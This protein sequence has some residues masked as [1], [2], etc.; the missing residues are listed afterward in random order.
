MA[1]FL[2]LL[3]FGGYRF[4]DASI[5]DESLHSMRDGIHI[6]LNENGLVEMVAHKPLPAVEGETLIK[7]AVILPHFSDFYSL[8]QERG[9]GYDEN[10]NGQ[11]QGL[12]ARYLIAGGFYGVRD[13]VF[14]R[15]GLEPVMEQHL[16]I[17]AQRGYL[18]VKGGPAQQFAQVIDP[19]GNPSQLDLPGD[20]P[21]TLWWTEMG[22]D[23][24]VLWPQHPQLVNDIIHYFHTQNRKVGCYIQDA[25]V[26]SMD[27]LYQFPFDFYEGMPGAQVNVEKFPNI[28]WIP[29]GRLNDKRY[30]AQDLTKG[31]ARAG[32]MGLYGSLDIARAEA[33]LED[34]RRGIGD[35][36]KVWKKRRATSFQPLRDW[37]ARKGALGVGS[38][39]GHLFSFTGDIR[40]ELDLL[41]ELGA[42]QPQLL[43]ALFETNPSLLGLEKPYLKPGKPANFIVFQKN[44]FWGRLVGEKVDLNFVDGKPFQSEIS[45][46]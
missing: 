36:C 5:Y 17:F 33:R 14:P 6:Q 25:G 40:S 41:E 4:A 23:Q 35:R 18:E 26:A 9:L 11:T 30:C 39:G 8:I 20:G 24:P 3:G 16:K 22:S 2:I 43:E 38:A 7:N 34:V 19:T 1:V 21:V 13:P 45:L 31:L 10:I 27:R 12:M 15:E 28:V 44:V 37:I 32:E 42:S 46:K 29:L